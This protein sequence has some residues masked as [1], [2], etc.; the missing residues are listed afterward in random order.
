ME[1]PS[2]KPGVL[3]ECGGMKLEETSATSV[4]QVTLSS[5]DFALNFLPGKGLE[6]CMTPQPDTSVPSV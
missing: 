1:K 5:Q 6:W 3:L 4:T 2:V